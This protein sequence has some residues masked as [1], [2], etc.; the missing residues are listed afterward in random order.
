MGRCTEGRR[1]DLGARLVA[2][3]ALTGGHGGKPKGPVK[4]A[5]SGHGR[6]VEEELPVIG[7]PA[8]STRRSKPEQAVGGRVER[9][10]HAL[11]AVDADGFLR[12]TPTAST[13]ALAPRLPSPHR[14][15]CP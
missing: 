10:V 7:A 15:R 9:E 2:G 3:D 6:V 11:G 1:V 4:V 12:G 13:N 8:G 5:S 14:E